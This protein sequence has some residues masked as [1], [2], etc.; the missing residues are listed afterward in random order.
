MSFGKEEVLERVNNNQSWS[1][2]DDRIIF[3]RWDPRE[4]TITYVTL[5]KLKQL[6]GAKTM[7]LHYVLLYCINAQKYVDRALELEQKGYFKIYKDLKK[8]DYYNH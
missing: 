7:N 5:K 6:T 2:R 3:T 8:N 1:E 4:T